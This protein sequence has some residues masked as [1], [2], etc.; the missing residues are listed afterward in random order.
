M[1]QRRRLRALPSDAFDAFLA[2]RAEPDWL[3]QRRR[4]AWQA[5]TEMPMPSRS[6]EEWMRTDIRAV[7]AGSLRP[8]AR[9]KSHARR[10]RCRCWRKTWISPGSS[11]TVNGVPRPL[12]W[13]NVGE[14]GRPV[15]QSRR[16]S[17]R[18]RGRPAARTCSPKN[19]ATWPDRF[20][21]LHTAC[22]SAGTLLYVPRG[23]VIDQP[24]HCPSR[25][26]R[27]RR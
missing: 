15:W 16:F 27:R 17:A 3:R 14:Q 4:D 24:L 13:R 20:A 19:N 21:A 2:Q 11:L 5:F 9:A 25:D 8:A 1:K 6:E 18:P 7:Q 10:S 12:S 23:V 22:W 26:H